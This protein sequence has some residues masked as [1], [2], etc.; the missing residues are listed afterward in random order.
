MAVR[1]FLVSQGV[2]RSDKARVVGLCHG[3]SEQRQRHSQ[4]RRDDQRGQW[5]A[6]VGIAVRYFMIGPLTSRGHPGVPT[7]DVRR[8]CIFAVW[9]LDSLIVAPPVLL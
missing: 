8:E 1:R 3:R 4:Y 9:I 5:H 2:G 7:V 6:E